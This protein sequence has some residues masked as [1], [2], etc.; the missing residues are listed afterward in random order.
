MALQKA[1][2]TQNC[3][4]H[5]DRQS[6]FFNFILRCLFSHKP[7]KEQMEIASSL[8]EISNYARKCCCLQFRIDSS[9]E[10]YRHQHGHSHGSHATRHRGD[11]AG[12]LFGWGVVDITHHPLTTGFSLIWKRYSGAW[13]K[14]R[15]KTPHL[16]PADWFVKRTEGPHESYL[17]RGWCHSR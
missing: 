1:F 7:W 15:S 17:E 6:S 11:E 14:G 4:L 10:P 8:W 2:C 13:L 5:K 16:T 12:P 9:D 3:I